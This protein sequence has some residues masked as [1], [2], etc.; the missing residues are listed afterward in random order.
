MKIKIISVLAVVFLFF[1]MF[2]GCIESRNSI[3]KDEIIGLW[4]YQDD[5]Y[6]IMN[7]T[8]YVNDSVFTDFFAPGG[9]SLIVWYYYEVRDDALCFYDINTSQEFCY[10]Y[11]YL[12]DTNRLK[13]IQGDDTAVFSRI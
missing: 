1:N 6:K 13:I 7:W 2:V 3:T 11:D 4:S 10:D 8:F 9:T 5:Q 12:E